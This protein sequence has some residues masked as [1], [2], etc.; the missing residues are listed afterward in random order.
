M[1]TEG[2]GTQSGAD[3]G[4]SGAG[5]TN[6]GQQNGSEGNNSGEGTQSGAGNSSAEETVPK[7]ELE[8]MRERMRAADQRAG[9][10]ESDLAQLRDKD[11]PALEKANRDLAEAN[12]RAEG[13]EERNRDLAVRVAF[14]TD[15]THTWHNP[16]RALKLVDLS[17]V[18]IGEDGTVSGMKDAI[19]ALAK[20]DPYLVKT[21]EKQQ[22]TPPGTATGNNGS[23]GDSKPDATKMVRRLP[24]LGTRVKRS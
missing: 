24:V 13:L 18:E 23:S 12:K 3:G 10:A 14:L 22:Q 4:Q 9:K 19:N 21:E 7:S 2:E 6:Q 17:K 16:D 11:M 15:N 20:S 1:T 8:K 5:E